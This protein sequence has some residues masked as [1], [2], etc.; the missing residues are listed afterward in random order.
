[1]RKITKNIFL[2]FNIYTQNYNLL[3]LPKNKFIFE[4]L[5]KL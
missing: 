4:K 2:N 3:K 5:K 1:M